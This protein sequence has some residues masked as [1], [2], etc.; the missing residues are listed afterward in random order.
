MKKNRLL[1]L[2]TVIFIASASF[3]SHA[4]V[5]ISFDTIDGAGTSGPLGG[6]SSYS[7]SFELDDS[8]SATGGLNNFN[9]ALDNFE[10]TIGGDT[11]G[12]TDGRHR[13]LVSRNR[14]G[15]FL[16]GSLD[17]SLGSTFGSY[18]GYDFVG[19]TYD[20][21]G[22]S[23]DFFLDSDPTN[24]ANDIVRD[25]L[26]NEFDYAFMTLSFVDNLGASF[27][28]LR[29]GFDTLV[30]AEQS[31]ASTAVPAPA[32]LVLLLTALPFLLKRRLN[33]ESSLSLTA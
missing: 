33:K 19:M 13:Q 3:S 10:I 25:S 29:I 6:A 28:T 30:F 11:F 17:N 2:F 15:G 32:T 27:N 31:A 21:R 5:M 12:G 9:G 7:G 20:F 4:T 8:V 24:L 22:A 23:A 16:A 18:N 1:K 26:I 14:I